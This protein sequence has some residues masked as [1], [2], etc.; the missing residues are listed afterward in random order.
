MGEQAMMRT[1]T[2]YL[3]NFGITVLLAAGTNAWAQI[4]EEVVVTAQKREQN[5]QEV[6]ISISAL[7]GS[8]L[9]SYGLTRATELTTKVPNLGLYMPYG[10][11]SSGNVI[12]RGIG[13][14]DFGEGHE[15]PVTLYVDELYL[16]S[17]PAVD[18]SMFDIERAEVLRGPQGTLFGRNA[19]AGLVHYVT[20]KPTFEPQGFISLGGGRFD[21]IKA[22]G[23]IGGA[24]TDKVAGR[25]SFLSH[26]SKG[27][28]KNLDPDLGNGGQAGTDAVRAQ[29]LFE[30]GNDWRINI[31][32]EYADTSTRH[33]YYGTVPMTVDPVRGVGIEAPD[34]TDNA[35]Y[36]PRNFGIT[37][38]NVSHTSEAQ[39]LDQDG[40][41]LLARI[42]KDV[43]DITLTSLTGYIKLDRELVE[44]CDAS[45]NRLCFA[46]F[47]YESD[48]VTTELRAAKTA[49]DLTWTV[50][51]YYMYQDA[52]N[53]PSATFN[54]PIFGP[55]A[56][57][58]ETGL[59]NGL[60][61]PIALAGDWTQSTESYSAFGQ[62][63]YNVDRWTLIGGLRVGRD[64]KNFHER[65]NATL[66]SCPG[67]PIPSNCFLP[68]DGPGIPNP[69]RDSYKETLLSWRVGANFEVNDNVLLFASISSSSKAGGFNNGFY[70]TQ[71][72]VDPSL[73]PYESE[74]NIAYEIGEKASFMDGRLRVNGSLFYYDYNDFQ[75]WNFLSFGG[76]VENTD[77]SSYG[78]ELE[79]DMAVS[80]NIRLRGGL[81]LL[82][83]NIED[84][85]GPAPTYVADRDMAMSPTVSAN[86]A[87]NIRVPLQGDFS[88]DLQWDWSY[89]GERNS[90]NFAEPAA[91]LPD[92]FKHNALVV[93][94]I[95]ENWELRGYVRNISNKK[96]LYR[97]A[98]FYPLGYA[99]KV[100]APPRVYGATLTYSF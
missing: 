49:G 90:A 11:G 70:S 25:V 75:V 72:G 38:N 24:L 10:P 19:T 43:G 86:G 41:S 6:G 58:P 83:T 1:R 82:E 48:W 97:Q 54:I 18:F 17:V 100:F 37:S 68:P 92:E 28:I 55:A 85:T 20:A 26:H 14:N 96:T 16:V 81:G 71:I 5:L 76:V 33:M 23:G 44:D 51:A 99:Q 7:S 29:L 52:E 9:Q 57:D 88:L 13:L 84:V 87:I 73:I 40:W 67:F 12:L 30:P 56:I 78:A 64:K 94:G 21:E 63:E 3:L 53:L 65:D 15:A 66:R 61:F 22:E 79:V 47:P 60:F 74:T 34:G 4:L 42:E 77:A 36:N 39:T 31:K 2:K 8:D 98:T 45:P 50:G 62:F 91:E 32:G 27:Y 69:Y 59:Y 93:L 95:N 80:D 35:G 46:D 89:L